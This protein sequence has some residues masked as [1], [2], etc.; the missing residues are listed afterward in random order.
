[1][2]ELKFKK[3]NDR[4][5]TPMR[6]SSTAAGYDL[7]VMLDKPNEQIVIQPGATK[8][9]H[10]GIAIEIPD[11][12]VFG[13]IFARSGMANKQGLRPSN[14]VGVIDSDYRGELLVSIHNDS[15]DEQVIYDRTKIAQ[16]VFLPYIIYPFKEV[17]E[18]SDTKRGEGGFGSTGA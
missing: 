15:F 16:L 13:A 7:F 18:L 3:L 1:M 6:S 8:L 4:A 11:E 10:T 2:Q 5:V 17:E 14:C 9:L 12:F